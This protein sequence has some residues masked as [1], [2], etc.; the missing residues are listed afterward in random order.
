MNMHI[1]DHQHQHVVVICCAR[2][3][4]VDCAYA[5]ENGVTLARCAHV[6]LCSGFAPR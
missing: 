5:A 4:G 6:C 3:T 2:F 1:D